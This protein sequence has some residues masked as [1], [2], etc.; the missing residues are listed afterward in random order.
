MTETLEQLQQEIK[1]LDDRR[2]ELSTKVHQIREQQKAEE[3]ADLEKKNNATRNR[4]YARIDTMIEDVNQS[5][6]DQRLNLSLSRVDNKVNLSIVGH[7]YSTP[8]HEYQLGKVEDVLAWIEHISNYASVIDELLFRCDAFSKIE[9]SIRHFDNT[10]FI[11]GYAKDKT[12]IDTTIYFSIT[13]SG[14][15]VPEVYVGTDIVQEA[16]CTRIPIT[17]SLYLSTEVE[18]Y[19]DQFFVTLDTKKYCTRSEIIP[20]LTESFEKILAEVESRKDGIRNYVV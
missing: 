2:L 7:K 19:E 4:H 9:V 16:S 13:F 11:R 20:F 18:N 6:R 3:S 17:D 14:S 5:M 12:A 1:S 15:R 10:F 8:R